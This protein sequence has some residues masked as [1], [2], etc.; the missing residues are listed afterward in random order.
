M[1]CRMLNTFFES[2]I[3]RL[4]RLLPTIALN[5]VEPTVITTANAIVLDAAIFERRTAMRTM[6]SHQTE[7]SHAIA[8]Q[9]KLFCQQL[10]FDRRPFG[11]HRFAERH[12]P[13]VPPQHR[14]RRRTRTDTSQE[15]VFFFRQHNGWLLLEYWSVGVVE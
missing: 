4:R 14:S 3:A 2:A 12:R 1:I 11:F 7:S 15:F 13:P 9:R 8:K 6:E 10:P 5:A